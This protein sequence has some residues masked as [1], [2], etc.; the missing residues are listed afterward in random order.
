MIYLMLLP[1]RFV[2]G[3]YKL[4][5]HFSWQSL[6]YL[7]PKVTTLI[8]RRKHVN[9]HSYCK[10]LHALPHNVS[11]QTER[12]DWAAECCKQGGDSVLHFGPKNHYW[13]TSHWKYSRVTSPHYTVQNDK[14]NKQDDFKIFFII[15][16][17]HN[18]HALH[19]I[20]THVFVLF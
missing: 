20:Y 7:S 9:D 6:S 15:Y 16:F 18:L 19:K 10:Y 3:M 1:Q 5:I 4:R 12:Y 2:L 8:S 11:H 17:H 14:K 13:V